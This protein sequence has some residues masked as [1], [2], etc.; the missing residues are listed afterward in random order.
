MVGTGLRREG[1]LEMSVIAQL[2]NLS[3]LE[4]PKTIFMF[5]S[6]KFSLVCDGRHKSRA[7]KED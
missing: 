1:S 5:F 4:V 7:R 3:P 2:F 6:G